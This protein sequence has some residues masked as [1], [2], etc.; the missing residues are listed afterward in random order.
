MERSIYD[1]LLVGL[2]QIKVKKL[3]TDSRMIEFLSEQSSIAEALSLEGNYIQTN[4][5]QL[6]FN[7]NMRDDFYYLR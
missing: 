5:D 7:V 3:L 1:E 2:D 4:N 6:S